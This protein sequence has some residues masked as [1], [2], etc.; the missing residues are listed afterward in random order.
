LQ[1]FAVHAA[2]GVD[3]FHRQ[4]HALFVGVQ[5]CG[6]GFVAVDLANLD[7]VLGEGGYSR[8]AQEQGGGACDVGK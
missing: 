7:D 6:L 3:L 4:L 1:L 2:L 5:K 8:D